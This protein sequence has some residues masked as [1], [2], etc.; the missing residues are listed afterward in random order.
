[1]PRGL[2]VKCP[3]G[4]VKTLLKSSPEILCSRWKTAQCSVVTLSSKLNTNTTVHN[5]GVAKAYT[6]DFY[7]WGFLKDHVYENRPQSIAELKV[8]ITQKIHAIGKENCV[9][10]IDNFARRLQVCL[11]HNGGQLEHVL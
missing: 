6:P 3:R 11:R 2:N 4:P 8:A 5:E 7:L 1:M 10:T 9:K